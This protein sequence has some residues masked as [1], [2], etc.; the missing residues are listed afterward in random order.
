MIHDPIEELR[1]SESFLQ[2]D[3]LTVLRFGKLCF[4]HHYKLLFKIVT[5]DAEIRKWNALSIFFV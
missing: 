2:S 1:N 4:T 5:S 3:G